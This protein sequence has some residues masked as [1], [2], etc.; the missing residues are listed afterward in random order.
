MKKAFVAL[1]VAVMTLSVGMSAVEAKRLGGGG[2]IGKQSSSA[3]RQAQSPAPMQQNQAAAA[4]PAA[5]AAAPA[6]AAA[7]PSMW[8]GLLGGALLGLGLGALLSHFG[9][10]GALASMISTIL[11]VALIAL[12]IM[13][14]IRLFRRKSESAQSAQPAPAWA[15]AAPQAADTQSATPQI[16]SMLKT[17]QSAASTTQNGFGGGFGNA[18]AAPAYGIPAGFDTVGFVRN[19]KTYFIRLQAAWDKADINDIRE[20]TTPEMFA[21]LRLQIQER[22]AAANQTDVVSLDAEVLGV[23][24]VGNDYLASVKFFGFIKEDPTASPAQFAEIWN[25]SKPAA[26]QGG[27]VLAGI[28]QLDPVHG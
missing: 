28:Q 19:A 5:P 22:G 3:S 16:G 15:S 25:L 17:D 18:E 21:E 2:S 10:G 9:L 8:K 20:F 23:E 12:A 7:K 27:W 6:A 4:K 24:T 13:F 26:G 11:T 1:I 14:V